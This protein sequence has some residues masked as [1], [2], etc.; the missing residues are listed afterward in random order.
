MITHI[1]E[2]ETALTNTLRTTTEALNQTTAERDANKDDA[3]RYRW[4]FG[5]RTEEQANDPGVGLLSPLPQ[6][7]VIAELSSF[8]CHKAAVDVLVDT[9][10][11]AS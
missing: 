2:R 3:E 9:A 6:D 1:T 5:A 7:L 10:K 11:G 8:Y 4:L